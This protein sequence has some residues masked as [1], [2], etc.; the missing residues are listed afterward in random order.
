MPKPRLFRKED[1]M[2][3][4]PKE[5]ICNRTTGE[6]INIPLDGKFPEEGAYVSEEQLSYML[7]YVWPTKFCLDQVV[8]GQGHATTY[9][10]A[11]LFAIGDR[12]P[13]H[14][15][16]GHIIF[17]GNP[18]T[19]KTLLGNTP[20]R[21]FKAT[22]GRLQ[23]MA[24]STPSD[25][26]GTRFFDYASNPVSEG[27]RADIE[28]VAQN[29]RAMADLL[30]VVVTAMH[31]ANPRQTLVYVKGPG[32]AP[33]QLIDEINRMSERA[34]SGL[35]EQM[36]EGQVTQYGKTYPVN[37]WVIATLNPRESRGVVPLGRALLDRFM[38][39]VL[40]N[41]F[42]KGDRA[43]ILARTQHI[44]N[45]VLPVLGSMADVEKARTFFH[46]EIMV[47]DEIRSLIDG[48]LVRLQEP[49]DHAGVMKRLAD[50]PRT[51]P[52]V[53]RVFVGGDVREFITAA[54]EGRGST[55]LEGAARLMAVLKYRNFVTA[56]DVEKVLPYVCAHRLEFT[57]T[58]VQR[59]QRE[60]HGSSRNTAEGEKIR[61]LP[62]VAQ[63]ALS[64]DILHA[65]FADAYDE[66]FTKRRSA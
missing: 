56:S 66:L 37:G 18:G 63:Q 43:K 8:V 58:V 47:S 33:L 13:N 7:K 23:A 2:Q 41:R 1:A 6:E 16:A 4:L 55:H 61:L 57:L 32:H 54:V 46:N 49:W 42:K 30:K 15:G 39:S 44:Q 31:E 59:Y 22:F 40:S 5:P 60:M 38:F 28:M 9:S 26:T 21:L 25:Y 48:T 29:D 17:K 62:E 45:T 51:R 35:L 65:A 24:D 14:L 11:G 34:Q 20:Q 3:F 50:D 27:L 64:V 12:D 19:G 36:S 10:T 52:L 53:E